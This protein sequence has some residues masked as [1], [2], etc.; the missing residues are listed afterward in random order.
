MVGVMKES[1]SRP[2][3]GL[4]WFEVFANNSSGENILS[5]IG[6]FFIAK[7]PTTT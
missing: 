4:V 1:E 5:S 2:D 6:V 7:K 3:R